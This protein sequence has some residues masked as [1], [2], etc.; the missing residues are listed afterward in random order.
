MNQAI[1]P[2]GGNERK[3]PVYL[4]GIGLNDYQYHVVRNTGY[5]FPQI[6]YTV[7]GKGCLRFEDKEFLLTPDYC[8]YLPANYP[9]EY[10]T[11]GDLWE[12]HWITFDGYAVVDMLNELGFTSAMVKKLDDVSRLE[13]LFRKMFVTL[14]TDHLYG[15]ITCS[16]LIYQY[17]IEASRIFFDKAVSD[18][19]DRSR[20]LM[21]VLN[22][23]DENLTKDI[24]LSQLCEIAKVS[25]Q[26]LCRIFKEVLQLRP[27]EYIS[28]K[29]IAK[30]KELLTGTDLR[31][32][33][34]SFR[35]GYPD[36]SYFGSVFKK[37]EL[38]TPG[39]YRKNESS[40]KID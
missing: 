16:G 21:P 7:R 30:A 38:M 39:E 15:E 20:I 1:Y 28:K 27:I 19:S 40:L 3:L 32:A 9:H 14:K 11:V 25:P 33:D 13:R 26:H 8:F 37:Y 31:I 23:I 5:Y 12:T 18:N 35:V 22:Y 4:I 29:R 34:I 10:F 17:M 24:S 36:I 2:I 6:I